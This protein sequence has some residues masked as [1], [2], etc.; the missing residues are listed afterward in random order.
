MVELFAF[1]Y[2]DYLIDVLLPS[3]SYFKLYFYQRVIRVCLRYT[4]V[5]GT[6]PRAYSK[7][8]LDFHSHEY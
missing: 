2:P 4:E 5:S 3:D 1:T 8:F 6:F 7:S